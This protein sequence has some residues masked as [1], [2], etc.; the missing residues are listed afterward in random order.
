MPKTLSINSQTTL[1]DH[2]KIELMRSHFT[3]NPAE[4]GIHAPIEISTAIMKVD[5]LMGILLP[6]YQREYEHSRSDWLVKSIIRFGLM[7]S[8]VIT[9]IADKKGEIIGI[10][11]GRHRL[12]ALY[13][14][15]YDVVEVVSLIFKNPQDEIDHFNMINKPPRPLTPEQRLLNSHQANHPLAEMLYEIGFYDDNSNWAPS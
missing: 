8:V 12:V 3:E 1:P 7:K 2:K 6:Q 4:I 10:H 11:D 15:R 14:L 13:M 9:I 5:D